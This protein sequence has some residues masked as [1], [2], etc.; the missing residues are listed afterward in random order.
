MPPYPYTKEEVRG[1]ILDLANE[2]GRTPTSREMDTMGGCTSDPAG[3]LFGSWNAAVRAVGLEPTQV[4]P[5]YTAE[6]LYVDIRRIADVLGHTPTKTE[7]QEHGRYPV[8]GTLKGHL[9]WWHIVTAAGLDPSD[10]RTPRRSHLVEHLQE[11]A[12]L[13]ERTPTP[14]QFDELSPYSPDLYGRA[15]GTFEYAIYVAG[16]GDD[17]ALLDEIEDESESESEPEPAELEN[18]ENVGAD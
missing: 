6:N 8:S 3:R 15:F 9:S 10:L 14:E 13:L 17:L 12:I 7:Y 2:L 18:V 1:H 16:V 11:V 5:A 4:R